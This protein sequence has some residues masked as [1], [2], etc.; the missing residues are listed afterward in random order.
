MQ[1]QFRYAGILD[2]Q[3]QSR[4]ATN[5]LPLGLGHEDVLQPSDLRLVLIGQ[6]LGALATIEQIPVLVREHVDTGRR[7][8]RAIGQDLEA[9][10]ARYVPRT[11]FLQLL[12]MLLRVRYVLLQALILQGAGSWKE[13]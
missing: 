9:D 5:V 4:K 8:R 7:A 1:R 3:T 10:S 6:T 11:T 12:S 2:S 13:R